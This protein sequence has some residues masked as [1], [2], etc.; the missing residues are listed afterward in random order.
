MANVFESTQRRS[1]GE[2]AEKQD[3]P[4][5]AAAKAMNGSLIACIGPSGCGKTDLAIRLSLASAYFNQLPWY[6]FDANGDVRTTLSGVIE[7]HAE[8]IKRAL[9]TMASG[10]KRDRFVMTHRKRL[11]FAERANS[12]DRIYEGADSLPGL[13]EKIQGWVRKGIAESKTSSVRKPRCIVFIDEAGSVRDADEKFWP[14]MRMARNGGLTFYATGHRTTDWHPAAL[15]VIRTAI[16]WKPVDR[17]K[18]DLGNVVIDGKL[19]TEAKSNKIRYIIAD[20]PTV[21]EWDRDK[22]PRYPAALIVP[23]QPTSGRKAGI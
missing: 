2:P 16:L 5:V 21:L 6:A 22:D 19:C 23:A 14:R 17:K 20:N 11:A 13:I 1:A 15:A 12:A 7:Y 9:E 8:E 18:W 3:S 10:E 4:A